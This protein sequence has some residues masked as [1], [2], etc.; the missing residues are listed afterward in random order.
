M[1]ASL[2]KRELIPTQES[3]PRRRVERP[4]DVP[5]AQRGAAQAQPRGASFREL[6]TR[7]LEPRSELG[8]EP[9]EAADSARKQ[10]G[11]PLQ[12]R[13]ESPNGDALP[14]SAAQPAARA[15]TFA[16]PSFGYPP[17]APSE[18]GLGLVHGHSAV[19]PRA[20]EQIVAFAGFGSESDGAAVMHVQ[21]RDE[22]AGGLA[23]RVK[24]FGA[25]RVGLLLRAQDT[26]AVDI[27]PLLS[28][29]RERGLEV[30][31]LELE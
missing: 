19:D 16:Q 24:S 26:G 12:T 13:G 29:L 27:A 9:A 22:I 14:S 30:V 21:M 11:L 7:S 1:D 17:A 20:V 25:R 8:A 23:V 6:L 31:D 5:A 2:D 4:G 15:E 28:A 18:G 10:A 3:H